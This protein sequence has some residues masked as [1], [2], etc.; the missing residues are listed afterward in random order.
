M[1]GRHEGKVRR[2]VPHSYSSVGLVSCGR[3]STDSEVSLGN[4]QIGSMEDSCGLAA[5]AAIP[6]SASSFG[7]SPG[8][9]GLQRHGSHGSLMGLGGSLGGSFGSGFGGG[10]GGNMNAS[11]RTMSGRAVNVVRPIRESAS[12]SPVSVGN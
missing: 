3:P 1:E 9:R 11:N 12:T 8:R 2:G 5:A 4:S 7:M 10:F 6:V